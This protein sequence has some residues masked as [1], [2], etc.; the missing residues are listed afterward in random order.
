MYSARRKGYE[1]YEDARST[2]NEFENMILTINHVI[3]SQ[4][5]FICYFLDVEEEINIDIAAHQ[6]TP[7]DNLGRAEKSGQ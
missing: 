6:I 2:T 7:T 3:I 5:K 4:I 1:L